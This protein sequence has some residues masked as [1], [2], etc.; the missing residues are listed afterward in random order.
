MKINRVGVVWRKELREIFRDKRTIFAV[1]I[2]PLLLT[3]GLFA[4][5]GSVIG[6]RVTAER[7]ETYPVGLIG[8]AGA[9]SVRQAIKGAPNLR[10]VD[11]ATQGEAEARIKART[12]RAAALFPP[13][14]EARMEA[15]RSVPVTILV[16]AGSDTSEQVGGRLKAMLAERG[17]RLLALR[18]ME[19][20]LSSELAQPF[21]TKETPIAGGGTASTLILAT[22][23]PYILAI[24]AITGGL[25][26]ANDL[27]AGE[28]ERG[29][30]ETLLVSPASRRD[31][32]LGKFL[33]V[34]TVSLVSS[35]LSIVGLLLPFFLPIKAFAW[36]A[37][38]GLSLTPVGVIVMLLA[39]LPL[40]VLGAG[41]L[42][43]ISTF[44]R[45][46]KEAQTYLGPLMLVV[47]VPAMLSMLVKAEA[48]WPIALVPILNAALALK[49][50]LSGAVDPV[51]IAVAFAASTVYAGLAVLFCA[52]LFQKESVLL[53]A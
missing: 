27:V 17:Q 33:A 26:A 47:L 1:I 50:A 53:K 10:F 34:A 31:L 36:L 49:Q 19:S 30:L 37:K 45:N 8:A 25:Y 15:Q 5:M 28:K 41:V 21:Q 6:E 38:G 23:L 7:R 16:D 24:G 3:P 20:G 4:L 43:S 46:Q 22:I 18:L 52:H 32:V 14:A 13:D 42:L 44:A 12:L 51:F 35:A 48:A 39:Q 2:S 9:P 29:T 11:V 40:A